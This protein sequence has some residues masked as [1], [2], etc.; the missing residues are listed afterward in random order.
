VARVI[1]VPAPRL[2]QP[3][4]R[5]EIRLAPL[6]ALVDDCS[7]VDELEP[8]GPPGTRQRFERRAPGHPLEYAIRF[9]PALRDPLAVLQDF[10]LE[11]GNGRLVGHGFGHGAELCRD[12]LG[13]L[14]DC[15]EREL[16]RARRPRR[17]GAR[18]WSFSTC[19]GVNESRRQEQQGKDP[20]DGRDP[21]VATAPARRGDRGPQVSLRRPTTGLND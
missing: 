18:L 9:G 8:Q 5:R 7:E 13:L 21:R 16:R 6:R 17:G 19:F 14:V 15:V 3:L 1:E 20:D 12:H 2:P 4:E 10:A 11:C